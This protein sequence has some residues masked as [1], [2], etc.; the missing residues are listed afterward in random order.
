MRKGYILKNEDGDGEILNLGK[1]IKEYR[2]KNH[3][4]Q[5]QLSTRI[6]YDD[7][8][9]SYYER[10]KRCPSI[11]T[12][13]KIAKALNIPVTKLSSLEKT[14]REIEQKLNENLKSLDTHIMS[15]QM[16]IG[17]IA[18][19]LKCLRKAR[20]FTLLELADELG[21]TPGAVWQLENNYNETAS[22]EMI[23]NFAKMLGAKLPTFVSNRLKA[24]QKEGG[25]NVQ[26]IQTM[27]A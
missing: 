27:E 25:V 22:F 14:G 9:V 7:S 11:P 3:M 16:V 2:L 18:K 10:G 5:R 19:D 12:L 1:L 8:A 15:A 23:I 6:G 26:S 4:T 21:C 13:K 17:E 20:F 24:I